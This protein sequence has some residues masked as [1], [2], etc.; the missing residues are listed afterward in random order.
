MPTAATAGLTLATLLACT[1]V[2]ATTT[3]PVLNP[4]FGTNGVVSNPAVNAFTDVISMPDGGV[5]A[6]G[7]RWT[8]V[9]KATNSVI[10]RYDRTGTELPGFGSHGTVTLARSGY[11]IVLDHLEHGPR[12]TLVAFGGY[13]S[14]SG[15]TGLAL[16]RINATTGQLDPTFATGGILLRSLGSAV[17]CGTRSG[18]YEPP[19]M[20]GAVLPD[21]RIVS[22]CWKMASG[23]SDPSHGPVLIMVDFHGQPA[24][25][26]GGSTGVVFIGLPGVTDS[27]FAPSGQTAIA[28]DGKVVVGVY[29]DGA[30]FGAVRVLPNGR[31]DTSFSSDGI[32]SR[33]PIAGW[34]GKGTATVLLQ[35]GGP[36]R[37]CG[38]SVDR[39]RPS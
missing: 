35:S 33:R 1:V 10:I 30:T 21:G 11:T 8:S 22:T 36:C 12:G 7:S 3:A 17:R 31:R 28:A 2:S 25:S 19:R 26:F 39:A 14:S 6:T 13:T 15:I 37:R 23:K 16:V 18:A 9:N 38:G 20:D 27:H 4:Q 32:A 5:V 34:A 29:L 24:A